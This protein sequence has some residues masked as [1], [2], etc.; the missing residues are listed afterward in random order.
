MRQVRQRDQA[1]SYLIFSI[2][3]EQF[4][5]F[6]DLQRLSVHLSGLNFCDLQRLSESLMN[7]GNSRVQH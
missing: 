4:L 3:F 6:C 5:N 2:L 1:R 7:A